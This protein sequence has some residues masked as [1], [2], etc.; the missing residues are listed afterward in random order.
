MK[1]ATVSCCC[2]CG[3]RV[4]RTKAVG[5]NGRWAI[6]EHLSRALDRTTLKPKQIE[7]LLRRGR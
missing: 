7:L 2:G 5:I 1:P 4:E 3:R 6:A